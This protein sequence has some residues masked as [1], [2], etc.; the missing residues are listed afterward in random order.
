MRTQQEARP[1]AKK[2]ETETGRGERER[3]MREMDEREMMAER[4]RE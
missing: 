3:W 4:Q 2:G 1:S